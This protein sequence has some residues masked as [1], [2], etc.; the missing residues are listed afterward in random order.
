MEPYPKIL[1]LFKRDPKTHKLIEGHYCR[2]EFEYLA[3]CE[4]SMTEKI[5]GMNIRV[6]WDGTEVTFAGRTNDAQLPLHLLESLAEGFKPEAL[7][8]VFDGPACLYGEG[9][10]AKIQRGGKYIA[11]RAD[12]MLFDVMVDGWWLRRK[13]MLD[14]ASKLGIQSAPLVWTGQIADAVRL[15]TGIG[16]PSAFGDFLAEGLVLR[17]TTDLFA[18]NG[19]RIIAKIKHKDF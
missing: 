13:D 8:R 17:P 16:V 15:I 14:V 9:Y 10:G 19:E 11:D 18:R 1:S 5:D 3:S 12:F 2:P 6:M 7:A 4:W